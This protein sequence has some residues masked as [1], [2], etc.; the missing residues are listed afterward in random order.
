MRIGG[1]G[2]D[3]PL[4]IAPR[5]SLWRCRAAPSPSTCS[6]ALAT[7]MYLLPA[8]AGARHTSDGWTTAFAGERE[9]DERKLP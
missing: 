8:K 6:N 3:Q 1:E 9:S 7:E 5:K 2:G 4:R